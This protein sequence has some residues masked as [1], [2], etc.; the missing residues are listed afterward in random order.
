MK[1]FKA[2]NT[3]VNLKA[4]LL[5]NLL[6][7]IHLLTFINEVFFLIGTARYSKP[8]FLLLA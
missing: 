1:L 4:S 3:I 5:L 6:L 2:I 8:L 7:R